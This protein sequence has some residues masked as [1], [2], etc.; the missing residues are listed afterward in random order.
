MAHGDRRPDVI[1]DGLIVEL[2]R[3]R[4]ALGDDPA[5]EDFARAPLLA[6]TC[7]EALRMHPIVPI[8]RRR[9][10]RDARIGGHDLR[11]GTLLSPAVLL[12]HYDPAV[13]AEP[14][15]FRPERFVG[16]RYSPSE[17][18][19]FGGGSRRCLGAAFANFELQVALGTWLTHHR[20]EAASS[21]PLRLVMN[22]VT[23]R[24]SGRVQLRY[25]GPATSGRP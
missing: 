25:R 4:G 18:M 8:F 7:D 22:G 1:G 5:P 15:E 11:A 24:P 6:A 2:V 9:V 17:F 23:T 20:C 3:T 19:P 14:D 21:A 16:R 10:T 13:F 12:T